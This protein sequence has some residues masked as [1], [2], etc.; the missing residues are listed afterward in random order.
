[1][2]RR[3]MERIEG[4]AVRWWGRGETATWKQNDLGNEQTHIIKRTVLILRFS[5]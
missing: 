4:K 1:M 2:G 5:E 3:L